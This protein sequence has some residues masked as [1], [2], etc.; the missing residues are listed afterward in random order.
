VVRRKSI[1]TLKANAKHIFSMRTCQQKGWK[2]RGN[3][4]NPVPATKM[5]AE[6]EEEKE[7]CRN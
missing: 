6:Q 4:E 7:E 3:V 5:K 1:E 2:K